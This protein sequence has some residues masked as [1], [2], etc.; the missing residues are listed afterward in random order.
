MFVSVKCAPITVGTLVE[1]NQVKSGVRSSVDCTVNPAAFVGQERMG[2]L[3][4]GGKPL[5]DFRVLVIG[6]IVV[7]Q[8]DPV[9][10]PVKRRQDFLGDKRGIRPGIEVFGLVPIHEL[11][12]GQSDR[13]E[14]LLRVALPASGNSRLRVPGCP[15][16]MQRG[17]LPEGG[18]VYVDDGCPLG[19]L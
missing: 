4:L 18:F 1:S 12:V 16:L 2:S 3:P 5:I 11:A 14:D 7:D 17:A 13:T 9:A 8:K 6:G 19:P 10:P 15:G